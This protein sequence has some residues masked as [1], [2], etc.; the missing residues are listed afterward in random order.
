MGKVKVAFNRWDGGTLEEV[1]N[2]KHLVGFQEIGCH[3]IFD[4]KMDGN[5]T[6]KARLVVCG[7]TVVAPASITHSS[8][9]SRESV[10]LAFAVA[11]LN[12]LDVHAADRSNACLCAPCR[13]KIWTV[14]GPEF[15]SDSGCVMVVV[16]ALCG[17]CM[18]SSPQAHPGELCWPRA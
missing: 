6:R 17:P 4:V 1:R 15:G 9:V 11:G 3:V 13:K 18:G 2:G 8:V 14:A 5:F 7:H 16:R 12:D 10:R